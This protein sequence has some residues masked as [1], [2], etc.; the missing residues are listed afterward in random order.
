MNQCRATTKRGARC[1]RAAGPARDYCYQHDL[2]SR[3]FGRGRRYIV[4]MMD[5]LGFRSLLETTPIEEIAN[6]VMSPL[7]GNVSMYYGKIQQPDVE[8]ECVKALEEAFKVQARQDKLTDR[9]IPFSIRILEEPVVT[10]LSDSILA[11]FP[12]ENEEFEEIETNLWRA[13]RFCLRAIHAN[14]PEILLR[15]AISYGEC[16]LA[17]SDSGL[18]YIGKPIAEAY[19]WEHN[20]DWIGVMLAPSAEAI[21]DRGLRENGKIIDNVSTFVE[22]QVPLKRPTDRK[23]HYALDLSEVTSLAF[24][25]KLPDVDESAPESVLNKI[26]N[27]SDFL[28]WCKNTKHKSYPNVP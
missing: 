24:R 8:V 12:C 19:E 18:V 27:T 23:R 4:A 6:K 7:V 3:N 25:F 28:H 5:I 1:A 17:A 21:L 26:R 16:Y 11:F 22:Y 14:S 2:V 10:L 9:E 15:G 20:Q 13:A